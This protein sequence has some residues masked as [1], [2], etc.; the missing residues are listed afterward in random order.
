[1]N[2]VDHPLRFL[3][4][5]RKS[6]EDDRQ[7]ASIGDQCR[8]LTRLVEREPLTV[9]GELLTEEKSAKAPGRTIFSAMLTRIE[10]GEANAILCWDIDRLYRNPVDE[11]RV[12]WLLQRG[13]I[14]EIRTPYR[15]FYPQDAGLLMGVEGGRATDHIITLRKG[16]FRGFRGKLERGQR[17]GVAPPGYLN[18]QSREKGERTIIADPERFNLI[19]R[20]WDL[21]LMGTYSVRRIHQIAAEEWSLGSKKRKRLGGRPY[22]I[23]A[24]YRIFTDP[25]Y[26]GWFWWKT[27]ETEVRELYRGAHV[28]MITPEEFDRVQMILGTR[29]KPVPKAHHFA[30]T[31]LIRCGECGA[32]VTAETKCQIICSTCK[33]KFSSP[34]KD[35]CARCG[36]P[37]EAMVSPT[38]LTYTYYHCTKR[39]KATCTQKSIHEEDIE[40]QTD[41]LLKAITISEAFKDWAIKAASQEGDRQADAQETAADSLEARKNQIAR[42]LQHLNRLIFSPDTDWTLISHEELKQ[43]KLRILEDLRTIEQQLGADGKRVQDSLELTEKTFEF[44]AYARYWFREADPEQ[45]RTI[46]ASLGSNLTLRDKKL[47]LELRKPLSCVGEMVQAAP[48]ISRPFEPDNR[49]SNKR[50]SLPFEVEIPCLLRRMNAIRTYWA[51]NLDATPLPI[52]PIPQRATA[53]SAHRSKRNDTD[54]GVKLAA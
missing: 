21:I 29:G 11:G 53:L 46:L 33:L 51:T 15:V 52:F 22:S 28:P 36:T 43:E 2:E 14:R 18:D 37:I 35:T 44:A 38:R 7:A 47:H 25:F 20:A 50:E 27:P 5:C 17:P 49:R 41:R 48:D 1:M 13:I 8:E 23:S 32:M 9:V 34:N 45:K 10:R 40:E 6:S 30:Y 24:W 3:I 4:Y 26:S 12:R 39:K 54:K 16:V 31:G 42:Q 19:R